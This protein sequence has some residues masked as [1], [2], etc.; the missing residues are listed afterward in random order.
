MFWLPLGCFFAVLGT[1]VI[2]RERVREL[3]PA[4]LTGALHAG[5]YAAL[6]IPHLQFSYTDASLITNSWALML[7]MQFVMTPVLA[8]W[9]AQGVGPAPY[10]PVLR[11]LSFSALGHSITW[12]ALT[13]G[14]MRLSAAIPAWVLALATIWHFLVV[15]KVHHYI[16]FGSPDRKGDRS[17]RMR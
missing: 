9:Y 13:T 11:T 16:A 3:I 10:P 8:A 4:A 14:K 6:P 17:V 15:W 1:L 7:I 12:M 5:I 2:S